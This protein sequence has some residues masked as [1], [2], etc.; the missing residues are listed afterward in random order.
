MCLLLQKIEL[1]FCEGVLVVCEGEGGGDSA[2]MRRNGQPLSKR[3]SR[4]TPGRTG[5]V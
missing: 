1:V 2:K 5:N 3:W 4:R